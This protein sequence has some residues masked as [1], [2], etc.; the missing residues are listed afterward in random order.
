MNAGEVIAGGVLPSKS[1]FPQPFPKS[2]IA[3]KTVPL[4]RHGQVH[5]GRIVARERAIEI[6]KCGIQFARGTVKNRALYVN[7]ALVLFNGRGAAWKAA[8][9][10]VSALSSSGD[11][12]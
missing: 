8:V 7:G 10:A 3:A 5:Q 1:H 11:S 9:S 12:W 2:R 4:R 6:F